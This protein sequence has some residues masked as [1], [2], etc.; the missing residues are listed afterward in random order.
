MNGKCGWDGDR[1]YRC[2]ICAVTCSERRG[3]F[4]PGKIMDMIKIEEKQ[5]YLTWSGLS[6]SASKSLQPLSSFD[7]PIKINGRDARFVDTKMEQD[8]DG[9]Y[10]LNIFEKE[11]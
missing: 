3:D 11:L 4:S 6:K 9:S 1:M 2:D 5:P 8:D 10:Y 7:V